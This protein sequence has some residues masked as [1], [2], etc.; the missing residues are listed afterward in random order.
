MT[1]VRAIGCVGSPLP[2]RWAV[3]LGVARSPIWLSSTLTGEKKDARRERSRWDPP[4]PQ[5]DSI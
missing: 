1:Q 5:N 4:G 3:K 2:L